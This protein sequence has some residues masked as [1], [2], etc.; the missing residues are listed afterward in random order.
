MFLDAVSYPAIFISALVYLALGYIWYHPKCF[1]GMY[2]KECK[3]SC[4]EWSCNSSIQAYAMTFIADFL[5]C[6]GLA[7]LLNL[8]RPFALIEAAQVGFFAWMAFL[9]PVMFL[10]LAWG[11]KSMKVFLI[12]ALFNLFA[13]AIACGIIHSWS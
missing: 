12:D 7:N 1:G 8:T 5:I 10:G 11:K 6:W 4:D 13:V 9:V 3:M 2:C